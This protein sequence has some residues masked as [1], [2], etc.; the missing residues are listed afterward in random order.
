MADHTRGSL[1]NVHERILPT[2]P[3]DSDAYSPRVARV[4]IFRRQAFSGRRDDEFANL[5]IVDAPTRKD[6]RSPG[7]DNVSAWPSE[8]WTSRHYREPVDLDIK[9]ISISKGVR[10]HPGNCK[11][12]LILCAVLRQNESSIRPRIQFYVERLLVLRVDT[13][14]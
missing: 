12:N 10:D 11:P 8:A 1:W 4:A 9:K 14:Q 6:H 7:F 5:V 3:I 2:F 13:Q